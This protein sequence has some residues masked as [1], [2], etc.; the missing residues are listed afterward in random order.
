VSWSVSD[1]ESPV[2]TSGCKTQVVT[3]TAGTNLTCTAT[4]EGGTTTVTQALKVDSAA[5]GVALTGVTEGTTYTRSGR[6]AAGCSTTDALSGVASAASVSVVGGTLNGVGSY[7]A[8][9]LG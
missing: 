6:P 4:S 8:S 2:A 3:D 9:C 5:P 1:P 7:T